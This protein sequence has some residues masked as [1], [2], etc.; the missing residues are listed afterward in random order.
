MHTKIL[1]TLL[2]TLLTQVLAFTIP[3]VNTTS[4]VTNELDN[5]A[6]ATVPYT[7][8]T[9]DE[10][11]VSG[12]YASG[13]VTGMGDFDGWYKCETSR[14][15]PRAVDVDGAAVKLNAL[16]EQHCVQ[17]NNSGSHCTKMMHFWTAA[18]SVCGPYL[19]Y[20]YCFR[21]GF[22]ASTIAHRCEWNGLSGGYFV[23]ND[24]SSLRFPIHKN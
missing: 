10:D 4:D 11:G 18:V 20:I 5:L 21:A 2:F 13:N 12:F 24:P 8:D 1:L 9:K 14:G 16:G 7:I 23:F 17:E 6:L 3:S 15:S 22:A 19:H